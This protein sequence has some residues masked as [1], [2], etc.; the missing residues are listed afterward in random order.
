MN[1]FLNDNKLSGLIPK[2][3]EYLNNLKILYI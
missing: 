2:E 3:I 1:R